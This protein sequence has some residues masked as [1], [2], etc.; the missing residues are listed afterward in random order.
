MTNISN[1]EKSANSVHV[2]HRSKCLIIIAALLLQK[3]ASHNASFVTLKRA[4]EATLDLIDSLT[5]DGMDSR[6]RGN[7]IPD[8]SAL[9]RSNL[10]C[11]R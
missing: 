2:R 6:R 4:I 5:Y 10:F 8:A 7:H 11:H 3:I 1:I 9:Q